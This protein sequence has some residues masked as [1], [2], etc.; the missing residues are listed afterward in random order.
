MK[1]DKI[2]IALLLTFCCS[3][4]TMTEAYTVSD[5]VEKAIMQNPGIH[6]AEALVKSSAEAVKESRAELFAKASTTYSYTGLSDAP[7]MKQAGADVPVAHKNQY[8]WNVTLSQPLFTGF[9]LTTRLELSKLGLASGEIEKELAVLDLARDVKSA[10]YQFLLAK[11]MLAVADE[12]VKALKAHKEEAERFYEQGLI[13][14]NDLL[15]SIV[16]LSTAVQERESAGAALK[17][18]E[19]LVNMLM[20]EEVTTAVDIEDLNGTPEHQF[21]S[22][23]LLITEAKT[24]RPEMA[25]LRKSSRRAELNTKLAK[26]AYFPTISAVGVYE[27][28]GDN[29]EMSNND[30]E[31]TSNSSI[32]LQAEWTFFE[33]GKT[34]AGVR[35]S[36]Y[37][38]KAVSEAIRSLENAIA[39][40]V[41]NALLN[42]N[43]AEKNIQTAKESLEQAK[44]NW[45]ITTAQ[46]SEQ[47]AT[48]ADVLDARTFLTRADSNYYGALYGY[49]I[50]KAELDRAVGRK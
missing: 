6:E 15:K 50:Y 44:E 12:E 41:R 4:I 45:R 18:V 1:F 31:N 24:K 27:R 5:A 42:I 9:A 23:N 8:N 34:R 2:M 21:F 46:Y 38:K 26:S 48:S 36:N 11:K 20:N 19:S 25:L 47:V 49:M 17:S 43:V 40:E 7:V 33:W 28:S 13:P 14:K 16:A 22:R 37:E 10:C 39:L 35:K 3:G 30:Y 32:T 29:P